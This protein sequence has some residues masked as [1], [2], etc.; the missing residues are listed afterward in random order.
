M[1]ALVKLLV[2]GAAAGAV[3]ATAACGSEPVATGPEGGKD[4][5]SREAEATP[6]D[7]LTALTRIASTTTSRGEQEA[8]PPLPVMQ[9]TSGGR[10]G[11]GV[12][13]S[14]CWPSHYDGEAVVGLCADKLAFG[15]PFTRFD[16]APGDELA[17]QVEADEAPTDLSFAT[18]ESETGPRLEHF[19]LTPGLSAEVPIDLTEGE[20][21]VRVM[22]VWEAGDI[23]YEFMLEVGESVVPEHGISFPRQAP[24][25][26]PRVSMAALTFGE[27]VE[28]DGCLR[29][30]DEYGDYLVIWPHD[31]ALEVAGETIRVVNDAGEIAVEVGDQVRFGGGEAHSLDHWGNE[32]QEQVPAKCAGPY[33][34]AG[35][36]IGRNLT[37]TDADASADVEGAP[38]PEPHVLSPEETL[39]RD[40]ASYASD[41]DVDIDEAIRRL[42][43]QDPIGELQAALAEQERDTFAGLWL[44]HTPEYRVV[45]RFTRGGEETMRP[46]LEGSPLAAIVEVR[47]A[48]ATLDELLGAMEAATAALRDLG[49][50]GYT[51]VDIQGNRVQLHVAD[52]A[53]FA[54]ALRNA[55]LALPSSVEVLQAE[56]GR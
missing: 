4:L 2:C 35:T 29:V 45:V 13:G 27:L 23:S 31:H 40:A 37:S 30:R 14:Y 33:W 50:R 25:V 1:R 11:D 10:I 17:V 16:V 36:E 48:D 38:A 53:Q 55:G 21:Y 46:Y 28:E 3:L 42:K 24:P 44:E 15:G 54:D 7:G 39:A 51:V 26:G 52:A 32:L 18:F 22:G 9:M 56:A 43:L 47:P 20:Y 34:I 49:V 19:D 6:D 8:L 41:F 12:Q 5:I